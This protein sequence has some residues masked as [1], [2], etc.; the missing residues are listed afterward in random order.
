MCLFVMLWLCNIYV[1]LCVIFNFHVDFYL[2]RFFGYIYAQPDWRRALPSNEPTKIELNSNKYTYMPC[3]LQKAAM[4][5]PFAN[6]EHPLPRKHFHAAVA[7]DN[8][9]I[10]SKSLLHNTR[11][12]WL[13]TADNCEVCTVSL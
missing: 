4:W 7:Y 12:Y 11:T 2:I 8:L 5:V 10:V 13:L 1:A 9:A 3:C 6:A